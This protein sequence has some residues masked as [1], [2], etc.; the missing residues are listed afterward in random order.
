[1]RAYAIYMAVWMTRRVRPGGCIALLLLKVIAVIIG[2][3]GRT[4]GAV[5]INSC[6]PFPL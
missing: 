1:M 5:N 3:R 2:L 4:S 6:L